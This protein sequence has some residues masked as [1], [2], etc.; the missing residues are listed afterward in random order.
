PARYAGLYEGETKNHL[1]RAQ[2]ADIV[3]NDSKARKKLEG[4]LHPKIKEQQKIFITKHLKSGRDLVVLDIPL[5]F[6]TGEDQ[7]V[8]VKVVVSAPHEVQKKR[9][10][11][12]PGID[13]EKFN[14]IVS[15]QM[16]DAHKQARADFVI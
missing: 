9:A 10:L 2:L 8:D 11:A 14:A 4:I 15:T 5:L 13:E 6:E 3:F 16:L 7:Q 1:V 12:R